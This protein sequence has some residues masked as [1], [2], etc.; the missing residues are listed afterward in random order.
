MFGFLKD[1]PA[2][3]ETSIEWLFD[4][5]AWAL[6]NFDAG[7]FYHE[8]ILAV[9]SNEFFPGRESSLH[10]MANLIFEQAKG[11]AG[12][13]HWP[14]RL[15]DQSS[16]HIMAPPKLQIE[17]ALRGVQGS[18]PDSVDEVNRLTFTYDPSLVNN[19]EALIATYAHMLAHYLGSAAQEPPPGGEQNWPHCTEVLAVFLGFGLMFANSA[20]RFKVSSCGSCGGGQAER[21]S[22][23]S[24]FDITYALAMF[25]VL[26]G[27]PDK[28]VLRHLKKSLR[29]YYK[30]AARDV[31]RREE[32]LS[33]LRGIG[34]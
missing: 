28:V 3:D 29:S 4:L 20:S 33:R 17:G 1:K 5:Y 2:L 22:Y 34:V 25:A 12:M 8:T 24:Q 18:V 31:R 21:S 19:P 32:M 9:P 11:Y 10:G 23:L 15:I 6:R 26:K 7:V 14:T 13:A 16:C 27:M 30:Q